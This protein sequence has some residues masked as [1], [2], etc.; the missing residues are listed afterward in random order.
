MGPQLLNSL[1]KNINTSLETIHNELSKR[2]ENWIDDHNNAL[3]LQ[4]FFQ[5]LVYR[6]NG[7][8]LGECGQTLNIMLADKI[9]ESNPRI[10]GL[11]N[12]NFRNNYLRGK[13]GELGFANLIRTAVQEVSKQ[14]NLPALKDMVAGTDY[15]TVLKNVP[16]NIKKE[17]MMNFGQKLN[18]IGQEVQ[19]KNIY[20]IFQQKTDISSLNSI[21][22]SISL[23]P[24]YSWLLDLSATVKNYSNNTVT[25]GHTSNIKILRAV[26]INSKELNSI[27]KALVLKNLSKLTSLKV[28][29]GK[30]NGN[31]NSN[32]VKINQQH[33]KHIQGIY[34]L[35][36]IGQGKIENGQ[37]KQAEFPLF[38]MV[39]ISS[40]QRIVIKS[41]K[42]LI[43]N[44]LEGKSK[45]FSIGSSGVSLTL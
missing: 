44:L 31:G 12:G 22:A 35:T 1:N 2:Y 20:S 32:S 39:N 34:E 28:Y 10:K 25:L 36:G 3:Q 6:D 40:S 27:K 8:E 5:Y 37:F 24:S 43:S 11:F 30:K 17:V 19:Q 33:F 4:R 18:K 23:N 13:A 7:K 15:V 21:T 42:E 9:I 41:T 38:L 45:G 14:N 26:I 29:T 16:E